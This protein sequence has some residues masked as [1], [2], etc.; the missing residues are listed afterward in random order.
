MNKRG[1]GIKSLSLFFTSFW[2]QITLSIS[3]ASIGDSSEENMISLSI[4]YIFGFSSYILNYKIWADTD[5]NI[6]WES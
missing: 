4:F 6:H 5:E 1:E 3:N 2:W